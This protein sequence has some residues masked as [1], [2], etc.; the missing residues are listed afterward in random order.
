M[1][2]TTAGHPAIVSIRHPWARIALACS[3]RVP[4]SRPRWP[5]RPS[6]GHSGR[7]VGGSGLRRVFEEPY[8]EDES[9]NYVHHDGEV[10]RLD[11]TLATSESA[12]CRTLV[13][14]ARANLDQDLTDQLSSAY[15]GRFAID[16][17][18]EDWAS[19]YRE[20]LHAAYLDVVEQA[21]RTESA[22]GRFDRAALLA[23]RALDVDPEATSIERALLLRYR[24]TGSHSAAAEQL[25]HYASDDE[26]D[27]LSARGGAR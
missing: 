3:A 2:A 20:T 4:V 1:P 6:S 22:A 8:R 25:S 27:V 26:S 23:R 12:V 21:I 9:A 15:R 19:P 11:P 14:R 16:F 18:Y 17:E 5:F 7:T 10:V 13:E 24:V